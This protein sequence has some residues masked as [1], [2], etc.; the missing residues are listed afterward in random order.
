MV[1]EGIRGLVVNILTEFKQNVDKN[2]NNNSINSD[3]NNTNG[4]KEK[5]YISGISSLIIGIS[6][7]GYLTGAY[8]M[9]K[10]SWQEY[11]RQIRAIGASEFASSVASV[12]SLDVGTCIQVLTA[13]TQL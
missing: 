13:G 4:I 7:I 8:Y 9:S 10:I 12:G 2:N 11:I 3:E 1:A 6:Q 5:I